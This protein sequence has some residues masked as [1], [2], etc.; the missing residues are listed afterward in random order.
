MKNEDLILTITFA[1]LWG[2]APVVHKFLLNKYN[3]FTIM[4]IISAIY[5]CC[6]LICL[7]YYYKTVYHDILNIDA[8]DLLL[9]LFA[10]IFTLFL[11]NV[12]Y[13]YVLTYNHSHII[14]SLDSIAP[15]FTLILA[16][17]LLN[18]KI[19]IFGLLG[20]TLIVLGVICISY[21]DLNISETFMARR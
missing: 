20:T 18:E 17:I 13:Y 12:I 10:G 8:R 9:F 15:F 1:F 5:F 7:P 16:Y 2:V 11:A 19:N 3:Q 14:S 21:N 4:I 6:L